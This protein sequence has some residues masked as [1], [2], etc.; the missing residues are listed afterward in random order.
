MGPLV[1]SSLTFLRAVFYKRHKKF[2]VSLGSYPFGHIKPKPL[3]ETGTMFCDLR[4]VFPKPV[5]IK[6][7]YACRFK[8]KSE[9]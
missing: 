8:V 6:E 7:F 9:C 3:A 1:P 5:F 2:V 4:C